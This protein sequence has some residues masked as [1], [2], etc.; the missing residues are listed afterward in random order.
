[1]ERTSVSHHDRTKF[2]LDEDR[3]PHAFYNI[4]ADMSEPPPLLP[5]RSNDPPT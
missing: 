2:I 5:R 4:A 1:M 3:I